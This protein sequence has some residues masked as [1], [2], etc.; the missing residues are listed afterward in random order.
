MF[1]PL[2]GDTRCGIGYVDRNL[3]VA[4]GIDVQPAKPTERSEPPVLLAPPG[5]RKIGWIVGLL[6]VQPGNSSGLN[7]WH[8]PTAP[9]ICSSI[10]RFSSSAYSM[11]SSRAI[12]STNPRTMVAIAS[13]SVRPRLM[14]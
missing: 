4:R 13:S 10:S 14:R 2:N 12:G 3:S 8:Q 1:G 11:G 6:F 7:G 9:S 5:H